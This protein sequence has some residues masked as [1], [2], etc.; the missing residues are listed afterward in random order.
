M[1]KQEVLNLI[2]SLP[3]NVTLDDIMYELYI[4]QK[5]KNALTAI[6]QGEV[7]TL[8]EVKALLIKQ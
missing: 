7:L 6:D 4:L 1:V 8:E 5:H 3:E 2:S